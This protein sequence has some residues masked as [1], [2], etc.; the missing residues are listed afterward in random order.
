MIKCK[1]KGIY[2]T[3]LVNIISGTLKALQPSSF[4]LET[5]KYGRVPRSV[6]LANNVSK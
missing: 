1:R 2:Y 6:A 5:A 3:T 4:D